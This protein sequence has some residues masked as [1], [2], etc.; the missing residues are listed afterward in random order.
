[1]LDLGAGTGRVQRHLKNERP[2]LRLI[3]IEP[4]AELRKVGYANGLAESE[5][6][7]GD[8]TNLPFEDGS[9]DLCCEFGVLHHVRRPEQMIGEMLRVA[10]RAIFI[11]DSNNFGQGSLPSRMLKQS[12]N[13]LGLWPIADFLKTGGKGYTLSEGDGLAYS[14]SVYNNYEQIAQSCRIHIL[15]TGDAHINP[16]RS[17]SHVALLGIKKS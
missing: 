5:L 14:Y 15:N 13:A 11:S 7:A 12:L 10:K 1:M 6:I 16:Y 17:A 8:A 9:F 4:V 2:G 3:G